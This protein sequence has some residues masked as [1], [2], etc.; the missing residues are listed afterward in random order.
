MASPTYIGEGDLFIPSPFMVEYYPS[1]FDVHRWGSVWSFEGSS[2]IE[3]WRVVDA[4]AGS[5]FW[6]VIGP[7]G[8]KNVR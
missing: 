6:P 8:C 3:S 5:T 7:K 2:W 4:R 1:W